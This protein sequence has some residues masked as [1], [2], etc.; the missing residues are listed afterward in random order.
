MNVPS[1]QP[2]YE[3]LIR[4][5]QEKIDEAFHSQD[6]QEFYGLC[7]LEA[8]CRQP[9]RTVFKELEHLRIAGKISSPRFRKALTDFY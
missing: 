3:N 6:A 2:S 4:V 9:A 7:S 5:L 8:G 1:V